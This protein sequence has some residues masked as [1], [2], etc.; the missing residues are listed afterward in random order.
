MSTAGRRPNIVWL[1]S[2]DCS[3]HGAE[4]G[5]GLARTPTIDRLAREGVVFE[6]MFTTYPVCAPARF[7]ILTGAPAQRHGAHQ[8]RSRPHLDPSLRTY[9]EVMREAGYFCTNNPKTDYNCDVDPAAVWDGDGTSGDWRDRPDDRPFLAVFNANATHESTLWRTE[10]GP[11]RPDEVRVPPYLPDTPEIRGDIA[12]YYTAVEETDARFVQILAALEEDGLTEDTV[13]LYSSDHGGCA[14]WSKRYCHDQGLRVPLVV[15]APPRWQHLLPADPGSRLDEPVTHLDVTTTIIT[16]GGA[17]VPPTMD[18]RP[19]VGRD[20]DPHAYAFGARDR[21]DERYDLV[22]TV[23]DERYRLLRNYLPHRPAG[24]H[25]AFAW[26]AAG[27]RSW[28]TE[29]RAGRLDPVQRRFFEPRPGVELYDCVADPD[30]LVDLAAEPEHAERVATMQAALDA[31]IL[32]CG[33]R[34]FAPEGSPVDDGPPSADDYPLPEVLALATAASDRDPAHV[35]RFVD[36][37]GD[38]REVVRFWG[39]QGLLALGADAAPALDVVEGTALHDP[40]PHVRVPAAEL[41]A[42]IGNADVSV[43]VLGE[44]AAPGEH[45]RLRLQ[46]VNALTYVGEAAHAARE[47]V[48]LAATQ[49]DDQY[50]RNAGRYLAAVL[51]GSYTPESRVFD[52]GAP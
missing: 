3:P 47:V 27:Y 19:L 36:A 30:H 17:Q 41:L 10:V 31:W 51:D 24:Q 37:L 8:M 4:L 48:G 26:Q 16:L 23:R 35:Q 28:E 13:V 38:T 40:S 12:R 44:L 46:A 7:A 11:V 6:N 34:G 25:Q 15:W 9:P 50:L 5:D 32:A 42:R 22:R 39:A 18:G 14:P 29:L 43:A 49:T 45:L 21:M 2:E 33:D 1:V 20:R 52:R